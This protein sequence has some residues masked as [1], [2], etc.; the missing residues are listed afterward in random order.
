MQADKCL[1]AGD[2][3]GGVGGQVACCAAEVPGL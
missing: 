3:E 1:G 2:M